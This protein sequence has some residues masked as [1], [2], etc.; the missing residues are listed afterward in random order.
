[1]VDITY[2]VHGTTTDNEQKQ[3]SGWNEVELSSKGLSQAK[4]LAQTIKNQEF[5]VIFCSDLKRAIQSANLNFEGRNIEIIQDARIR[6]CNYGDFNGQSSSLVVYE[7]HI[8]EP[9][10]NG[11]C[12]VQVESRIQ[13]FIEFLKENYDGK[14][15]AIV[16]HRAPQLALDVI[17]KQMS[18]SEAIEQDWRKTKSWQP[19]WKYEI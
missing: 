7:D 8:T 15:V 13:E 14:K 4:E 3:A 12:L 9:F 17:T 6:E 11:E 2:F 1:M 5:D 10:P 19:G 16:A 18:W